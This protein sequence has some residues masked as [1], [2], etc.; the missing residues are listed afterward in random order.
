MA[1]V[2]DGAMTRST[3]VHVV[4]GIATYKALEHLFVFGPAAW[5]LLGAPLILG[6]LWA[7]IR[8]NAG[9]AVISLAAVAVTLTPA[10][11]NHLVLLAWVAATLAIFQDEEQERFVLRCVLSTMYGFAAVAKIW[12]DWIS[13]AALAERTWLGPLL[14]PN[15]LVAIAVMTIVVEAALAYGVWS[16]RPFWIWLAVVVHLSFLVF[17]YTHV[18]GIARL[19]AFGM[20]SL[21]LWL[22]AA[23]GAERAGETPWQGPLAETAEPSGSPLR[24]ARC[25]G[26]ADSLH[27]RRWR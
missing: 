8:P 9:L 22:R 12:P 20:L 27:R 17:T 2:L 11:R 16:R 18:W 7:L 26:I 25:P 10:Y 24:T 5:V 23:R 3:L 13:G 15:A 4:A 1:H 21:S 19:A 6:A 14:P